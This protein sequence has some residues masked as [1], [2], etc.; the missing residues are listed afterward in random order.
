M[1]RAM[2]GSEWKNGRQLPVFNNTPME[3][4][5][6]MFDYIDEANIVLSS[7]MYMMEI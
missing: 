3:R 2:V 4:I 1:A 5:E 7:W 6:N